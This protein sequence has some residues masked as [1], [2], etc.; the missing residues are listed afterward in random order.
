MNDYIFVNRIRDLLDLCDSLASSQWVGVDTETTGLNPR[1][2]RIRLLQIATNDGCWLLDCFRDDPRYVWP[3]LVGKTCVMHNSVFDLTFLAASRF[4]P[5]TVWDTML[6]SQVLYCG[7]WVAGEIS[8]QTSL[9]NCARRELGVSLDKELQTADWGGTLTP[10]MLSYAA[11]DAAVLLPLRDAL[12]RKLEEANLTHVAE[13]ENRAVRAVAWASFHGIGFDA[14][15]WVGLCEEAERE[16]EAL[17]PQLEAHVPESYRQKQRVPI[18]WNSRKES[19]EALRAVGFDVADSNDKTLAEFGSLTIPWRVRQWREARREGRNER[20]RELSDELDL[21]LPAEFLQSRIPPINWHSTQQK[22][23]I[24]AELGV[25][26]PRTAKGS[27][28]VDDDTLA[29]IAHPLAALLRRYSDACKRSERTSWLQ[30]VEGDRIFPSWW[31]CG[32]ETGRMSCSAPPIQQVPR[33]SSHR[34]CFVAPPGRVL[35]KADYSQI[36]LRI[37]AVL[38]GDEAMLAAYRDG[39]DLHTQTALVLLGRDHFVDDAEKK[40]A[41]QVAKSANFGLLYGMGAKKLG[42]Y[43]RVNYGVE[44]TD[45]EAEWCHRVFFQAYPTLRRWQRWQGDSGQAVVFTQ[46]GR[47]RLL[48]ERGE[49]D[50]F[51]TRRLNTPVQGTGADGLKTALALLYERRVECPDAFPVLVAHDEIVVE[52][53]EE[54]RERTEAWLRR[55]MVDGMQPLVE[56]VEAVVESD[57]GYDWGCRKER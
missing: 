48:I 37:A 18:N 34:S 1:R 22:A 46:L 6:A 12:A 3:Y 53:D 2:D 29:G 39:G 5:T 17:V 28:R 36:E 44:M 49:D 54:T 19:L 50:S 35:I 14:K 45:E 20:L 9:A 21:L 55:A 7:M 52:C 13:L 43:A 24:L 47:R 40:S 8:R 25:R 32:T 30:F 23:A 51:F 11:R 38:S 26:L 31:Q 33:G 27:P 42:L 10:D 16:A 57:Y 56:P 41:R 4:E 15:R